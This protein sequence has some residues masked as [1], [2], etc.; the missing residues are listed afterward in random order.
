MGRIL[1]VGILS[2]SL[3]VV[4]SSTLA[5]EMRPDVGVRA[6]VS[7]SVA[8]GTVEGLVIDIDHDLPLAGAT[9]ILEGTSVRVVTDHRGRFSIVAPSPGRFRI[10][11][12][13]LGFGALVGSIEIEPDRGAVVQVGMVPRP[14]PV[15]GL[16]IC[17]GGCRSVYVQVH[18]F[19][20][21]K[22]PEVPV[23]LLVSAENAVDSMVAVPEVD[24]ES[25][26]LWAGG[27]LNSPELI[28]EVIANGYATWRASL[29]R[30]ECGRLMF[31]PLHVWLL[32]TKD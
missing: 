28:V 20:S 17:N 15:C 21:S 29:T 23:T 22:A 9:I 6:A 1:T 27:E 7:S 13:I 19:W 24:L 11:V 14:I 31:R 8:A 3:A 12:E 5:Q 26:N 32:P 25:I 4:P 30:D 16:V 2:M 10:V 18:D